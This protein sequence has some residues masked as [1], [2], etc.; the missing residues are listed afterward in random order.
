MFEHSNR[1]TEGAHRTPIP[2]V[3]QSPLVT[4][5]HRLLL[6]FALALGSACG[7]AAGPG[8]PPSPRGDSKTVTADDLAEA[9]QLNLY[10][11]LLAERPRWLR[12]SVP[13]GPGASPVLVFMDDTRLG[14][15]QTL[16][17]LS[18]NT[19]RMVRYYE[20]SAAQQKFSGRDVGA[21][22]QVLLK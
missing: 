17:T 4:R 8:S 21:V 12:G 7:T 16:R 13:T 3:L 2:P 19:I 11:Y 5:R 18:L 15:V 1:P 6:G 22:I 20:P 9:T 14:G 10:D